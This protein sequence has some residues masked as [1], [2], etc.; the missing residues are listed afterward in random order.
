MVPLWPDLPANIGALASVRTGVGF[1][2]ICSHCRRIDDLDA[3][4]LG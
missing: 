2:R 1:R 3:V 4:H